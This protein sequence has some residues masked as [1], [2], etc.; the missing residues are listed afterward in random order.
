MA[1]VNPNVPQKSGHAS[2]IHAA[3]AAYKPVRGGDQ[4]HPLQ[5]LVMLTGRHVVLK[6]K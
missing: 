1:V 6:V 4:F 5:Q 3:A 2:Q